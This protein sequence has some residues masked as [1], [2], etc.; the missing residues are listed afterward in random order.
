MS[1]SRPIE[2]PASFVPEHAVAFAGTDGSALSVSQNQPLPVATLVP[3][4][5]SLALATTL[6]A[7]GMVGPFVPELGRTIWLTLSGEWNGSVQLL[8]SIDG[9]VQRLPLTW[10]DGTVRGLF[11]TNAN[12]PVGEESV[13]GATWWLA[14][15][16]VSGSVTIRVEQ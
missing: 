1:Q 6:V 3:A 14:V 15:T 2:S 11:A 5:R 12:L 7:S 8:R 16:L 4:A 10:S 9:G 13:A